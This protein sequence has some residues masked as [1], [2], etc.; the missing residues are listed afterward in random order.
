[1]LRGDGRVPVEGTDFDGLCEMYRDFGYGDAIA[2]DEP[3][4]SYMTEIAD[5]VKID[6]RSMLLNTIGN[7]KG[8][9][10]NDDE[11]KLK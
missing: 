9:S 5:G 8:F 10:D 4:H 11:F 6:L 7:N 3:T 2:V 1:M